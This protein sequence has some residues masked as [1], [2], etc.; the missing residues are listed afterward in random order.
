SPKSRSLRTED[1][2]R[3]EPRAAPAGASRACSELGVVA[4]AGTE[5]VTRVRGGGGQGPAENE[6]HDEEQERR[7]RTRRGNDERERLRKPKTASQRQEALG[8]A[9]WAEK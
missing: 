2:G 8:V 1:G 3:G 5:A 9:V 6:G 4:A 7:R